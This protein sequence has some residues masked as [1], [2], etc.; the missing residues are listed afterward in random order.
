[1][2]AISLINEVYD[3]VIGIG[4]QDYV[5][6]IIANMNFEKLKE[7]GYGRS[8][9]KESKDGYK[10]INVK[11][12]TKAMLDKIRKKYKCSYSS[13]ILAGINNLDGMDILQ[14]CTELAQQN[15][16]ISHAV[17]D[18]V[19]SEGFEYNIYLKY[20][21]YE[22]IPQKYLNILKQIVGYDYPILIKKH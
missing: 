2:V 6:Y 11:N 16:D 17:S 12:T 4:E 3:R 19:W 14:R 1:M 7:R 18:I 10:I 15:K 21:Q 8:G 13:I 9:K 5:I 20:H 22:K